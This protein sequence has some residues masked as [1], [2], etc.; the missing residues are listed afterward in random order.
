MEQAEV[1]CI[2]QELSREGVESEVGDGGQEPCEWLLQM[3]LLCWVFSSGATWHSSCFPPGAPPCG[4]FTPPSDL[5]G[6][7]HDP[8]KEQPAARRATTTR[9]YL[10][11]P[12]RISSPL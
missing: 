8:E 9:L 2:H 5:G 1:F 11:A 6:F 7:S 4:L 12:L 10:T 3:F